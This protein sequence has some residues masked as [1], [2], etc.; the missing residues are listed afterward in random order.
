MGGGAFLRSL[1]CFLLL[2]LSAPLFAEQSLLL[3]EEIT[4]L[5]RKSVTITSAIELNEDQK[6]M[7]NN[8]IPFTFVYELRLS[9]PRRFGPP[10]VIVE[11]SYRYTL[12]YHALSKQ[13]VVHDGGLTWQKSYPTL[14]LALAQI[15]QRK[16][17]A[18]PPPKSDEVIRYFGS[19]RL[20]LDI[21][22]LPAP[23]RIPAY[24]SRRWQ[25]TSGWVAFPIEV[26][27]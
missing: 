22:A 10:K 9:T 14:S 16:G 18:I 2:T 3:I 25:L 6:E 8:G 20:R 11:R 24:L 12:K 13:Y 26:D 15:K 5:K 23:L 21:E 19:A 27:L 4:P 1:F 17:L 7:L